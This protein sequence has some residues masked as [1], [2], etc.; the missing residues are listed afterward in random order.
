MKNK[1]NNH[2]KA[3]EG[4]NQYDFENETL[5]NR[6]PKRI[7]KVLCNLYINYPKLSCEIFMR[8]RIAS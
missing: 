4:T 3:C 8:L 5:L 2:V 6:Y 1:L 7:L